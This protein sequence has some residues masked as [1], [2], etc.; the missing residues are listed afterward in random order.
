MKRTG[1]P[2]RKTPLGASK[3]PKAVAKRKARRELNARLLGPDGERPWC[4]A[5]DLLRWAFPLWRCEGLAVHLHEP[6]TRARGGD[7]TDEDGV[8]PVCAAC[9]RK[10]HEEVSVSTELGLLL[11]S[12]EQA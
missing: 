3:T 7:P 2:K 8:L 10:I 9:H 6:L 1:P 5:G 12:W 4:E 11:H